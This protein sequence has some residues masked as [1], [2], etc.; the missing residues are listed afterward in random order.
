M[1]GADWYP[2]CQLLDPRQMGFALPWKC[3]CLA[4]NHTAQQPDSSSERQRR[5]TIFFVVFV[6]LWMISALKTEITLIFLAI[7]FVYCG[8]RVLFWLLATLGVVVKQ[9]VALATNHIFTLNSDLLTSL[10][11][12]SSS[13]NCYDMMCYASRLNYLHVD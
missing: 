8:Y 11:T 3:W 7:C 4:N 12:T 10:P 2:G 9:I 6:A 13:E 1:G 5:E